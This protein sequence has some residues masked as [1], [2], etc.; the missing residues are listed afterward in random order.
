VA[1]KTNSFEGGTN[2]SGAGG[3]ITT[4][5]SGGTNGDAFSS[6]TPNAGG[7]I[8]YSSA[9]SAHGS[10]SAAFTQ[11]T[12]ASTCN[13]QM[14]DTAAS[15]A[16]VRMYLRMT[17]YPSAEIQYPFEVRS[18]GFNI[19][20]LQI[21]SAGRL[22]TVANGSSLGLM[23]AGSALSLNTWYR[24]AF[25]CSAM[26]GTTGTVNCRLYTGDNGTPIEELAH[27][28]VT[29][30]NT[31][32]LVRYGRNSTGSAMG[33]FYIDDIAQNIGSSTEISAL[34]DVTAPTT[35]TGLTVT[36][37]G[38]TTATLSWTAATDDFGVTGYDVTIFGP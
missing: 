19:C 25:W 36:S 1:L 8:D 7:S 38:S 13:V 23:A 14:S 12:A 35:P 24:I 10:L 34:A 11:T 4:G 31:P 29:T 15:S 20:G 18:S 26:N 6:V 3:A 16:S 28:N 32:S 27:T 30:V 33:V 9:V 17:G 5:N 2:G 37:I 21:T 22:R